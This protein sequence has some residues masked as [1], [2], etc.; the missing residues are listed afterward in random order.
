[1][2]LKWKDYYHLQKAKAYELDGRKIYVVGIPA[3]KNDRKWRKPL[4]RLGYL[5]NRKKILRILNETS[6]DII[7]AHNMGNNMEMAELLRNRFG[8]DFIVTARDVNQVSLNNIRSNKTKPKSIIAINKIARDRCMGILERD[9]QMMVHPID[10]EFYIETQRDW[11]LNRPVAFVS[12]CKLFKLKNLDKVIEAFSRIKE[13]YSYTIIGD[14]PEYE[15]LRRLVIEYGL[16]DKVKLAGSF[17]YDRI[18]QELKTFDVMVMPSYPETLGRAFFE[19]LASGLPIIAARNTGVDGIIA[20]GIQGFVVDHNSVT[21]I[22]QAIQQYLHISPDAK[23]R[24]SENAMK[25]ASNFTWDL[26]LKKYYHLYHS[27]NLNE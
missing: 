19:A 6:P 24:M 13:Q 14:G 21:D 7:H 4:V 17:S 16:Q 11:P 10:H 3:F 5:L 2:K 1:L 15:N 9:V 8:I 25:L 20:N 26:T 18:K 23:S 22:R 12:V 27:I